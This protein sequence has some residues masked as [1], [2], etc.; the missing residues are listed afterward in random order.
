MVE[1]RTGKLNIGWLALTLLGTVS[2]VVVFMNFIIISPGCDKNSEDNGGGGITPSGKGVC[3]SA[4]PKT[5]KSDNDCDTD[6]GKMCCDFAEGGKTC[7]SPE[8][9]PRFCS[10]DTECN[11][12]QGEACCRTSLKSDKKTCTQVEACLSECSND[13][14]C[15]E[16]DICCHTYSSSICVR[17]HQ[18]PVSCSASADCKTEDGEICCKSLGSNADILSVSGMCIPDGYSCPKACSSSADCNTQEGELCCMG[19]C[20][21]S[22]IKECDENTDCDMAGGKMCCKNKVVTTVWWGDD[23]ELFSFPSEGGGEGDGC[24]KYSDP[25]GWSSDGECDCDAVFEWDWEDCYGDYD[26]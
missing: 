8:Y 5:C 20:S 19:F 12:D 23:E 22:C 4:C 2:L 9:C 15:G 26:Y 7:I 1:R 6:K 18:C 17:P 3:V 21:N 14:S 13:D 10:S 24:C 16:D 25:C 11:S